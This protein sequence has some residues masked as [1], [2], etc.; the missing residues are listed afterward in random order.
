MHEHGGWRG[1]EAPGYWENRSNQ[2]CGAGPAF[3]ARGSGTDEDLRKAI[4]AGIN[5]VRINT[6]LR[7][8]WGRGLE[9]GLVKQ[10]DEVVPSKILPFAVERV[11]QV[12]RSGLR[13]TASESPLCRVTQGQITAS[14]RLGCSGSSRRRPNRPSGA[15]VAAGRRQSGPYPI[16]Q[17]S[18]Q[19]PRFYLFSRARRLA[20]HS[21]FVTWR[22]RPRAK[23]SGG[24]GSVT[25]DP[26]P[27]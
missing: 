8:A 25:T 20:A 21:G 19:P 10:P 11:R 3:S 15:G 17:R 1:E 18:R 13:L 12:A 9:D 22:A 16:P 7:V 26:A 2:E 24:T 23:A 5:I 27:R 4:A 6:E 14:L